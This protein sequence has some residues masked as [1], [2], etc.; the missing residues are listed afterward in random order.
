MSSPRETL[1]QILALDPNFTLDQ[2]A[3]NRI[4]YSYNRSVMELLVVLEELAV[5]FEIRGRL[6]GL[7]A[8]HHG[9]FAIFLRL[10]F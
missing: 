9:M 1:L 2:T 5:P 3:T 7:W 4:L 10:R 8:T 6:I